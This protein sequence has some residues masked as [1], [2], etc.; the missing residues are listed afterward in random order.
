M[1]GNTHCYPK[2][3][4]IGDSN[5]QMGF[6]QDGFAAKLSNE[7][8]RRLDIVNRG[9]SGYTSD[10][11][12]V[13]MPKLLLNDNTPIGSLHTAT[14]L[15]GSNDSVL[16]E[17]DARHVPVDRYK[18][19]IEF[20]VKSLREIGVKNIILISPPPVDDETWYVFIQR[21]V[22]GTGTTSN[23]NVKL[24][25]EVCKDIATNHSLHFIDL[26][27]DLMKLDNWKTYFRDGLHFSSQGNQYLFSNLKDILDPLFQDLPCVYPDM[28]NNFTKEKL[29]Q[30]V[31]YINNENDL[32]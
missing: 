9:F 27:S 23:T 14:I 10:H 6:L 5:T 7:Y 1:E 25:A 30:G 22:K 20:I 12:R 16:R 28:T 29:F 31:P 15:L 4:L 24:Y 2:L 11:L 18:E 26:Y 3:Y 13:M 8:I 32:L 19:N 21:M 17:L